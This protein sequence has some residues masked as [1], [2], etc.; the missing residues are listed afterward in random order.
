MLTGGW[1][2]PVP[3]LREAAAFFDAHGNHILAGACKD[4]IRDAGAPVPRRGR[5][6]STVPPSLQ[7]LGVTSREV[8]VL[9]LVVQGLSNKEI[10]ARLYLS[11][12]TVEKHVERLVAKTGVSARNELAK[13]GSEMS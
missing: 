10:A 11:P 12:R 4:L 6:S 3:W 1:G 9:A 2:D 8:D 5:G 13:Y 7:A